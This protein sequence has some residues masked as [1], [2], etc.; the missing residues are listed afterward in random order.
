MTHV[1]RGRS[2]LLIMTVIAIGLMLLGFGEISHRQS[3]VGLLAIVIGSMV[4]ALD[5]AIALLDSL[6]AHRPGWSLVLILL[7][8]LGVG[9]L[10][11][12]V[13]GFGGASDRR[14]GD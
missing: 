3:G 13:L 5:W 7:L 9:P 10:V 8:P 4:Y 2:T 12:A 1:R 11:Y 6:Q 14:N